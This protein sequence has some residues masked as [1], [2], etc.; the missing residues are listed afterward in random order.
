M[1]DVCR[2]GKRGEGRRE[3][4]GRSGEGRREGGEERGGKEGGRG[5]EGREGGEVGRSRWMLFIHAACLTDPQ[6][7]SEAVALYC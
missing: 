5:R 6:V 4:R 2:E 7:V 3:G 1:E